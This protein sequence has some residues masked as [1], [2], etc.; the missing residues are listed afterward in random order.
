MFLIHSDGRGGGVY[1]SILID[2]VKHLKKIQKN[3]KSKNLDTC[4]SD[5]II[6]IS[7]S[8]PIFGLSTF[9]YFIYNNNLREDCS[10]INEVR[11][12]ILRGEVWLENSTLVF[13]RFRE[14]ATIL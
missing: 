2:R 6:L 4:T 9:I 5:V 10:I 1:L 3:V 14:S 11:W 8:S 7:F 12:V 13:C